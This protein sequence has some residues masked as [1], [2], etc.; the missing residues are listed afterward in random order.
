MLAS[1]RNNLNLK[2]HSNNR[3]SWGNQFQK[4]QPRYIQPSTFSKTPTWGSSGRDVERKGFGCSDTGKKAVSNSTSFIQ[5]RFTALSNDNEDRDVDSLL[6]LVRKDIESWESSGQWLFSCYSVTREY[7]CVSGLVDISPEELRL[8]YYNSRAGGNL[9]HY[10]ESVRQLSNQ[11]RNRMLELK[12]PNSSA[13][14]SMITEL[15]KPNQQ[16]AAVGFGGV[17]PSGFNSSAFTSA[18]ASSNTFSFKPDAG[19]GNVTAAPSFG[20]SVASTAPPQSGF[21]TKAADSA[22]VFGNRPAFGAPSDAVASFSAFSSSVSSSAPGI[23]VF[24]NSSQ[25]GSNTTASS[26]FGSSA[27]TGA[28][29]G[30]CVKSTTD[31]FGGFAATATTTTTTTTTTTDFGAIPIPVSQ[32]QNTPVNGCDALYTPQTQLSAE[33][34]QEFQAKTFTLGKIPLRPPPIELLTG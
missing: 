8:E 11:H 6:E 10:V 4:H 12:K 28:A 2:P 26:S 18:T 30:S 19:L 15:K 20:N 33:D 7:A 17:Q 32:P 29:F 21:G 13:R 16:K 27:S 25:F 9:Q 24:G 14:A 22:S 34:L 3:G 23:S 31:A 1:L 5:N